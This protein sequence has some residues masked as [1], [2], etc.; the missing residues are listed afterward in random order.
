MITAARRIREKGLVWG[1]AGNVSQRLRTDTGQHL[2]AITPSARDYD[3]LRP[4][5]VPV[6]DLEGNV[7]EG[8][9][10]PSV[11]TPLHAAIYRKRTDVNAV[12]H[13]HSVFATALAVA[14]L[15]IP[16]I[17]EEQRVYLGG[18]I[19]LAAHAPSG[20][21]DLAESTVTALGSRNA[22]LLANHGA[23]GVGKTMNEALAA[24]ELLERLAQIYL[25]A[26]STGKFRTAP[27]N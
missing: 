12:I 1:T 22:V 6:L 2:M 10:K 27:E 21:R 26:W 7:I 5:D 23:V 3:L 9:L 24:C 18:E 25:L 8:T 20:S 15:E 4:E 13:T 17:L 16:I 14:D 19:G 11:E